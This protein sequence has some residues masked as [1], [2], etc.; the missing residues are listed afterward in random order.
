MS[1]IHGLFT[2]N[3]NNNNNNNVGELDDDDDDDDS[4][5]HRFVGGI[6]ARGGGR[7]VVRGIT[8]LLPTAI[9]SAR[10]YAG[11]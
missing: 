7:Y 9:A 6:D 11:G 10:G 2:N 3:N 5:N 1:N 8:T 4:R